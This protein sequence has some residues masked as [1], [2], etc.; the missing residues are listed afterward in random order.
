MKYLKHP[1]IVKYVD[2]IESLDH[3]N[4]VMEYVGN[5]AIKKVGKMPEGLV[6]GYV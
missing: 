2:C 4:I 5:G 1:K 6:L 3:L